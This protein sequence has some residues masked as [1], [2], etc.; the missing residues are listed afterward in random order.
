MKTIS[1]I[2]VNED[3]YHNTDLSLAIENHDIAKLIELLKIASLSLTQN[4]DTTHLLVNLGFKAF[5]HELSKYYDMSSEAELRV[6][7]EIKDFLDLTGEDTSPLII[8][9]E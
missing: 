1:K 4:Q 5:N 2:N 3:R 8:D 6:Y 7:Y 9:C